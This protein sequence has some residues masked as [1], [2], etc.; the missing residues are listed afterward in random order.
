M[1]VDAMTMMRCDGQC[2]VTGRKSG[3]AAGYNC[4]RGSGS[5][6]VKIARTA[7]ARTHDVWRSMHELDRPAERSLY[8][9]QDV[10][11]NLGSGQV[12]IHN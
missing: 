1:H 12:V 4:F 10:E 5:V 6:T 9:D 3:A 7:S 11:R 2:N 8:T